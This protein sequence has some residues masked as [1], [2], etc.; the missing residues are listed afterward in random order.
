MAIYDQFDHVVGQ[1]G[2]QPLPKITKMAVMALSFQIKPCN[3]M[4]VVSLKFEAYFEVFY[5]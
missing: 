5:P 2:C 1:L 3:N 4:I